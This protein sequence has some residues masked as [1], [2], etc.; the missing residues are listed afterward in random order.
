MN[1][2]VNIPAFAELRSTRMAMTH[3]PR[4]M[5]AIIASLAVLAGCSMLAGC[6]IRIGTADGSSPT[7]SVVTSTVTHSEPGPTTT[8]VAST[9]TEA[10]PAASYDLGFR[11]PITVPE[12]T[13]EVVV[14]V[15]SIPAREPDTRE[16]VQS[17]VEPWEGGRFGIPDYLYSGS[18]CSSIRPVDDNG[19]PFYSVFYSSASTPG[20][21]CAQLPQIR[22]DHPGAYSRRL[23]NAT[24][25]GQPACQAG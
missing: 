20:D 14:F 25:P 1:E 8:T 24:G 13:G 10:A 5:R 21:L 17:W 2:C 6:S 7:Q 18:A 9:P 3:N 12:C 23:T 15:A 19:Q 11:R 22:A 4:P 16:R